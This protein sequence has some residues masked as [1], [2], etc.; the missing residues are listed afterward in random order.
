MHSAACLLGAFGGLT[1]AAAAPL[2]PPPAGGRPRLAL[3]IDDIGYNP[4]VAA[5]FMALEVPLTLAILPHLP[6]SASLAEEAHRRGYEVMLHQPMEP[7]NP[8]YD[9]GPGALYVGD[10]PPTIDTVMAANMA[11]VPH[12]V[13]LNNHMGSRFTAE[14]LDI[15]NTL[16]FVKTQGLFF[17]DSIT[18]R[19][20]QAYRT[21]RA[22]QVDSARRNVF[23]DHERHPLAIVTQL[24]KLEKYARRHGVAV[25]I[26]HPY[27]ET[28]A[29]VAAFLQSGRDPRVEWVAASS[30]CRP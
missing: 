1:R 13:G 2:G 24:R 14:A 5:A 15:G 4:A 7:C 26:G 18:T 20:S 11:S 23:L 8:A 19:H 27:P 28:A 10:D 30:T 29:A 3:I 6:H 22:L 17:V 21:A 9:P 16:R 12:A 25:G